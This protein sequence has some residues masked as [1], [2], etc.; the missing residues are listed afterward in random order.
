MR[1]NRQ[2]NRHAD[3]INAILRTPSG[4]EVNNTV[5][6]VFVQHGGAKLSSLYHCQNAS[7]TVFLPYT[8]KL[9]QQDGAP[10]CRSRRN[11]EI[12]CARVQQRNEIS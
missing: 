10:V 7:N 12:L 6:C 1:A 9:F 2:T 11:V 3:T 5:S 4:G 8:R